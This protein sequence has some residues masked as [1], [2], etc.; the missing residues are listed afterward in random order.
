MNLLKKK[1]FS[2]LNIQSPQHNMRSNH[3]QM[4]PKTDSDSIRSI[5]PPSDGMDNLSST[6]KID[7]QEGG[8]I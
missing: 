2:T 8:Q 1:K 3:F 6:L 4:I 7:I 5:S